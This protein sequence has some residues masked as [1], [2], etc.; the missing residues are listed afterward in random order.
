MFCSVSQKND[1]IFTLEREE[2]K[3]GKREKNKKIKIK[4]KERI[5]RIIRKR[6]KNQFR[7]N[8]PFFRS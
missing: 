8:F 3:N 2:N 5:Q 1:Y 7:K 4:G 6:K